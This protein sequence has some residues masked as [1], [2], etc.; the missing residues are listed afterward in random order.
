MKKQVMIVIVI[1]SICLI[2]G[3]VFLFGIPKKTSSE[4][5]TETTEYEQKGLISE[6]LYFNNPN[7]DGRI[8]KNKI[9]K[10]ATVE[11]SFYINDSD[12]YVDFLGERMTAIPSQIN[13]MCGLLAVAFFNQT[14]LQELQSSGDITTE[15]KEE[16]I[17][18]GYT[19][20]SASLVF[21]DRETNEKI[22]ECISTGPMWDDIKFNA[23]R[24]YSNVGSLLG[25]KIGE[26]PSSEE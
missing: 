8:F 4:K 17:L 7:M 22:A 19:A 23:Y 25:E 2:A 12:E 26:M 21:F 16:N 20:K 13:I 24:D 15:N 18:E 3:G 10:T 14:A 5:E 1:I 9:A 6:S 11:M